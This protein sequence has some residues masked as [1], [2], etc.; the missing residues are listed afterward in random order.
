[1][2]KCMHNINKFDMSEKIKYKKSC[3]QKRCILKSAHLK[4]DFIS[5][6]AIKRDLCQH[7]THI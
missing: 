2:L 7:A 6:P 4:L 5:V 3:V 1:M